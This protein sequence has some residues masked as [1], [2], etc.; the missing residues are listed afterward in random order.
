MDATCESSDSDFPTP[1]SVQQADATP[2]GILRQT[3]TLGRHILK[4]QT[5]TMVWNLKYFIFEIMKIILQTNKEIR[6]KLQE[7]MTLVSNKMSSL[8]FT[9]CRTEHRY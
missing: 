2:Y 8:F 9:Q 6:K 3:I 5:I 7:L 1:I 4:W